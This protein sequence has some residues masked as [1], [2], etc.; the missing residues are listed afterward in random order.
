MKRG[1]ATFQEVLEWQ[2]S[3]V[4]SILCI[5]EQLTREWLVP[6]CKRGQH[7]AESQCVTWEN[8]TCALLY[9]CDR[10]ALILGSKEACG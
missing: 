6:V 3:L 4:Y 5:S 8:M 1:H 7:Y 10:R 2:V 9:L